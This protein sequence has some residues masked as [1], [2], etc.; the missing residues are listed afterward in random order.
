MQR[1]F[2]IFFL[3]FSSSAFTEEIYCKKYGRTLTATTG[4]LEMSITVPEDDL[5]FEFIYKKN[6]QNEWV[7]DNFLHSQDLEKNIKKRFVRGLKKLEEAKNHNGNF[8]LN[9]FYKI[10]GLNLN[11]IRW[12]K[13]N[14]N[15]GLNYINQLSRKELSDAIDQLVL[16]FSEFEPGINNYFKKMKN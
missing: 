7:I 2:I 5:G 15:E 6:L 14:T 3:F 9:D 1:I 16:I 4:N 10:F 8:T 12:E 13:M 11:Y